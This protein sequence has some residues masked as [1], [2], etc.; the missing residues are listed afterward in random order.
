MVRGRIG[1]A[2][3]PRQEMLPHFGK[4]YERFF[5]RVSE[6]FKAKLGDALIFRYWLN[7]WLAQCVLSEAF[8]R[9]FALTQNPNDT[10]GDC[11]DNVWSPIFE[12]AM[13]K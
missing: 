10:I 2:D 5:P 9:L 7:A 11:R 13:S 4:A 12:E 8:P 3:P 1:C 6:L